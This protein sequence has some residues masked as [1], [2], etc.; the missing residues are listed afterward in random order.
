MFPV[1]EARM[2]ISVLTVSMATFKARLQGVEGVT[3]GTGQNHHDAW[4]RGPEKKHWEDGAKCSVPSKHELP[5]TRR[6]HSARAPSRAPRAPDNGVRKRIPCSIRAEG[7]SANNSRA[8]EPRRAYTHTSALPN[9]RHTSCV[10]EAAVERVT[11]T[12]QKTRWAIE[13]AM[14]TISHSVTSRYTKL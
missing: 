10:R 7:T 6:E 5:D 11:A 3:F 9:H 4:H 13:N 2:S 12:V 8:T 1:E 14:R